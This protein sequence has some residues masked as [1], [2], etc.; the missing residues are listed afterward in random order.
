MAK[1]PNLALPN[2]HKF[3]S[4][5]TGGGKS[6]AV[7]NLTKSVKRCVFWDPDQEHRCHHY[8][9]K[10]QF[11]RA[12]QHVMV[13]GGRIGWAGDDSKTCFEWFMKAIWAAL[14]GRKLLTVVVEEAADINLGAGTMPPWTGK[15]WRRARKY[16][17]ILIVGTQR[18]QEVPKAFITQAGECY[19]G[20][21]RAN[22]Q[23]YI[24]R[25]T[26]LEPKKVAS[27]KP[28]SFYLMK[29]NSVTLKRFNYV[30]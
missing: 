18:V 21:Q 17:G 27:L 2:R 25:Q 14:D 10:A 5:I 29:D 7:K 20:Q 26:G 24:K 9:D 4:A 13:K 30:G 3:I 19:V 1:N 16:G 15:V 8:S 6:Q 28:L 11:L 22:D 23:N 12:L